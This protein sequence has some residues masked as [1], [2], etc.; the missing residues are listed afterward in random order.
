VESVLEAAIRMAARPPQ[1]YGRLQSFVSSVITSLLKL[2]QQQLKT[3]SA[4]TTPAPAAAAANTPSAST[5][6]QQQ[7]QQQQQQQAVSWSPGLLVSCIKA[8]SQCL[9]QRMT[10]PMLVLRSV[11]R[12]ASL[13]PGLTSLVD[14]KALPPSCR[15]EDGSA[16]EQMLTQVMMQTWLESLSDSSSSSSSSS[17]EEGVPLV[18]LIGRALHVAAR[19]LLQLH[20]EAGAPAAGRSTPQQQQREQAPQVM[21]V[22]LAALMYLYLAALGTLLEQQVD[23]AAAASSSSSASAADASSA[24]DQDGAAGAQQQVRE[25]KQLMELQQD[26]LQSLWPR[27]AAVIDSFV[28]GTSSSTLTTGEA[29]TKAMIP[30]AAAQQ[31]L[32]LATGVC[33]QLVSVEGA[34]QCCANPGCTN[35]SKLSEQE[36]VTGKGTVCSSCRAVRLC[37]AEC[38]KA[39]WKAGHKQVCKRLGG[40]K[41][42]T[43]SG[44][45]QARTGI[46]SSSTSSNGASADV[47]G[48]RRSS[49]GVGSAGSRTN[50]QDSSSTSAAAAAAG[51]AL[52]A[53]AAAFMSGLSV[54]ELKPLLMRMGLDCSAAVE[55]SDLV[56]ALKAHA[57]AAHSSSTSSS[58]GTSVDVSG[59]Q[60][61]AGS[62]PNSQDSSSTTAA[63][64]AAA[65]DLP[66]SAAAASALSVRQ[67]KA[68]LA[69]LGVDCSAA[70]EKS[71]LVEALVAHSAAAH[72]SS[73]SS[74]NG[75]SADVSGGR[76]SSTSVGS[77]GSSTSSQGSS[78]TMAAAL[79]AGVDPARVG[80]DM[81][82]L[83]AHELKFLLLELGLDCEWAVDKSDLE[84]ALA[85]HLGLP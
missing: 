41:K 12:L 55:K 27:A 51:E 26:L 82:A 80:A 13:C 29:E 57:A 6:P 45:K 67:L 81:A 20:E 69:E 77:A 2:Q 54:R 50:S 56:E 79:A 25:I 78:S 44:G 59:D 5:T 85:A 63:A 43:D 68:L 10:T 21:V 36:V 40:G 34:A 38:N 23:K 65:L 64:A 71:D 76:R 7:Q 22:V 48:G 31:L 53:S 11:L 28:D 72:S 60:P 17:G 46:S 4:E 35:Y 19:A 33:T 62:S 9:D 39:Y 66:V 8:L 74:S 83:P 14:A 58:G 15:A 16:S 70:V 37:S 30:A 42:Q 61:S 32:Q 75:T 3:A 52:V 47:S 49:T 1:V 73:T 24:A 18:L 84:R